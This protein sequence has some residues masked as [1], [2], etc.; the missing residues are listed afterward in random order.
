MTTRNRLRDLL[1]AV[2]LLWA[3]SVAFADTSPSCGNLPNFVCATAADDV[4]G[5]L[6]FLGAAPIVLEGATADAFEINVSVADPTTPDKTLFIPNADSATATAVD[7]SAGNHVDSF[8][9]ATGLFACTADSSTTHALLSTT[10]SDTAANA[11]LR[12][13]LVIGNSTPAWARVAVGSANTFLHSDGTDASWAAIGASDI[14]AGDLANALTWD[15]FC[16]ASPCTLTNAPRTADAA[17]VTHQT[18][19]LR[20]VSSC[21]GVN[22]YTLSGTTLTFCDAGQGVSTGVASA[23]VI[24]ER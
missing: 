7:C 11:P 1:L 5:P 9:P 22:E 8:D 20:R 19:L 16:T 3:P 23:R 24:Y 18:L 12:G 21:G 13:A 2:A 15:Q 6:T 4:T 10:H 14:G 17:I